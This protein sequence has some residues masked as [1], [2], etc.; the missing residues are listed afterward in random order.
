M[1]ASFVTYDGLISMEGMS[2]KGRGSGQYHSHDKYELMLCIRG[3]VTIDSGGNEVTA[4]A[5]CLILHR[6]YCIHYMIC[7]EKYVYERAKIYF[8]DNSLQGIDSRLVNPSDVFTEDLRIL[9]LSREQEK[10]F[11]Q[12]FALMEPKPQEHLRPFLLS[13]IL[14]E[15]TRI[16]QADAV[17]KEQQKKT[18]YISDV[19]RYIGEHYSEPLT[20]E[21]IAARYFVSVPKLNR[22]FRF[23]TQKSVREFLIHVRLQHAAKLLLNG[24]S[25]T[26]TTHLVGFASET[27]FIR[28]F[29]AYYHITPHQYAKKQQFVKV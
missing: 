20:A 8:D 14:R 22:D 9:P 15:I 1:K 26:N 3:E 25:V 11:C 10:L 28:T 16:G 12:L 24:Y 7:N 21:E 6:P 17:P 19:V 4:K 23:Y 13:A 29:K 27:H 5:P 2:T 18:M